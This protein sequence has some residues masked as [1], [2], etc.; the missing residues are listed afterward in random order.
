MTKAFAKYLL[1]GIF[2][3]SAF[4]K[5]FD[6]QNTIVFFDELLQ[7]GIL[8]SKIFLSVLVLL[9][10]IIAYLLLFDYLKSKLVYIFIISLMIVFLSTNILFAIN[11]KENC[12]CFG[13]AIISSPFVSIIKNIIVIF[14]IIY[15]RHN[16]LNKTGLLVKRELI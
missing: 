8:Y 7:I 10:I 16:L 12:G 5:L 6:Y 2:V 1:S 3:F 15:L 11:G 4:M 14:S 9:E 13:T